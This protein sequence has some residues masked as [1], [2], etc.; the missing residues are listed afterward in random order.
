MIHDHSQLLNAPR[1][2]IKIY[3]CR[4]FSV[5]APKLWNNL[6]LD[7]KLSP[8]VNVFKSRLKTYLFSLFLRVGDLLAE[9]LRYSQPCVF[10]NC[11][12]LSFLLSYEVDLRYGTFF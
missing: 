9:F 7:R 12:R 10:R 11:Y 1:Y 6:P 4:A 5:V 2:N 8:T 3:G